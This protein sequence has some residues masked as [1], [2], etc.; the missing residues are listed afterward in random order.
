MDAY[1]AAFAVLTE[2]RFVTLDKGFRVYKGLDWV[3]LNQ[4]GPEPPK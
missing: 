3:D 2:T 4:W 1:L